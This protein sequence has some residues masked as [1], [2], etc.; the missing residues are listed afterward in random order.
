MREV[1]LVVLLG[2]LHMVT[3]KETD[4]RQVQLPTGRAHLLLYNIC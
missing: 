2:V 4:R 3:G 1:V